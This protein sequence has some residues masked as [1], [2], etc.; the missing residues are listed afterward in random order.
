MSSTFPATLRIENIECS[1]PIQTDFL[2]NL[3][4]QKYLQ[5]GGD[6]RFLWSLPLITDDIVVEV[7]GFTGVFSQA[8]IN[9]YQIKLF[10]LEPIKKYY[11]LLSAKFSERE[12]IKI[13]NYGLGKSGYAD[14]GLSDAGTGIFS[15]SDKK[16]TVTLKSLEEFITDIGVSRIDILMINIEG[17][18]YELLPQ[19]LRSSYIERVRNLCIQFHLIKDSSIAEREDIRKN[20][21]KT[22]EEV[23]SYPF[24]WERW[25]LRGRSNI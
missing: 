22:H 17:G 12:N 24:V 2:Y 10:V 8:I 5:D 20:L 3:M 14:F 1:I 4:I 7:G 15:K 13:L 11:E 19:L 6:E 18:E 25:Q 23:F 21:N 16:E 9:R